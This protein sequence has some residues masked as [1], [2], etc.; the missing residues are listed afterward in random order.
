MI[1]VWVVGLNAYTQD[2]L[3][4]AVKKKWYD[5]FSIRGYVQMRY[6]RLLET[7]PNLQCDQ[8]DKSLGNNGG[9]FLRRARVILSG[10]I[11]KRVNFYFQQDFA[12]SAGN[13]NY[14][15]VRDAYFDIGIDKKNEY[16][17]RLGQSKV[18]YGFENLQSSSMR[19]PLDRADATNSAFSNERDIGVAF[20]WAPDN[21][22]ERFEM[23]VGEGYK[24][25]GDYGVFGI[26]VFNGTP[27]NQPKANN[28]LHTV[29]RLTYPFVVGSQMLEPSIQAYTG[30]Y[31]LT[32][33][34]LSPGVKI[35][36][37]ATYRDQR[38]A[39]SLILY[40]RPFGIQAEYNVGH[41]PEYNPVT[42][43]IE[44]KSLKGGYATLTYFI[45]INKTHSIYPFIKYQ[46]YD[47][48]KKFERDARSYTVDQFEL[49]V[50]WQP[51]ENF[52]LVAMYSI[53]MRRYEDM[54]NKNNTQQG[55]ALRLQAQLNF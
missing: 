31:T 36:N 29:A 14:G 2:T 26:G 48:G 34:Q 44:L 35:R 6:N 22:R 33:D 42:D 8:C 52:E 39:A 4:E 27:A 11:H 50:E 53:A 45:K 25:S 17:L 10:Q 3:N 5:R 20:Y 9:F 46:Y 49:G 16:R 54:L 55:N 15:Q 18:P 38:I 43:S 21:V 23:L 51:L 32:E 13:L 37:D 1:L 24:G 12:S 41:G 40:P 47:G 30:N 7:N 19:L 28:Q